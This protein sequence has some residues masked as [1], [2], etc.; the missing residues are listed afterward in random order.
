MSFLTPKA[1]TLAPSVAPAVP[2]RSADAIQKSVSASTA[3]ATRTQ[4][5]RTMTM[6][7]GDPSFSEGFSNGTAKLLGGTSKS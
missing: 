6:L 5:G 1:P 2:E 7:R 3:K 4:G